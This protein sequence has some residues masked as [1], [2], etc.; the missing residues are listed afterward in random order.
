MNETLLNIGGHGLGD[1]LLSLQISQI[2]T[3][4][5]ILHKNLISTRD[6]VFNPL[7]HLF[8]DIIDLEKIDESIA[9]NNLLLKD[10]KIL[11]QLSIDWKSNNITYNV[12]DLLFNNRLSFNFK[13]YQISPQILKKN[14]LLTNNYLNKKNIIYC[15]FSTTTPGYLY[16]NISNLLEE[17]SKKF[18]EY[19]I[20][21][22]YVKLWDKEIK[23]DFDF[24]KKFSNNV[25]IDYNPKFED[26]INILCESSYFIGT[27][28]GPSH[29][30]Y[31]LGIPR[32]I[33]DPQYNRLPWI[34]R[35]KEDYSESIPINT[36]FSDIVDI[37][38]TN[39]YNIETL[40][41]P[42]LFILLNLGINWKKELFIKEN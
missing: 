3:F 12:P 21:F 35:W 2:L 24:S 6:E 17:L 23:Y 10:D 38:Y 37:V 16:S 4:R 33:L 30:A 29:I 32:L 13:K 20:Y 28:N 1:C 9:N 36:Q 11:N 42:R 14:R 27:D 40:F 15:G 7:K 25:I 5:K 39:I 41:M 34:V 22:P 31:H 8:K 19:I 26:S 18:P